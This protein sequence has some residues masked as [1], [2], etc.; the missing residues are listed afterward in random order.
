MYP[1]MSMHHY[2]SVLYFVDIGTQLSR[3]E[4]VKVFNLSLIF[5]ITGVFTT[6]TDLSLVLHNFYITLTEILLNCIGI[7]FKFSAQIKIFGTS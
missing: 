3:S 2:L 1:R 7:L 4:A 6:L 5:R